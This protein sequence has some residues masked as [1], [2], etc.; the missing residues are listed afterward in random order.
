MNFAPAPAR[1]MDTSRASP[2]PYSY[3]IYGLQVH[4]DIELPELRPSLPGNPDIT[5]RLNRIERE[6]SPAPN[7]S[8]AEFDGRQTF[9]AWDAV[10]KFLITDGRV[11]EIEPAADVDLRL[12]AFPLLGPVLAMALHDRGIFVL[13]ASAIS[14]AGSGIAF[15]GDKGA[16]KST[17]A[18][19][20]I[21]AGHKLLSDDVV[22]LFGHGDGR[23]SIGSAFPQVKLA[24]DAAESIG[25][26]GST[27]MEAAHPSIT[28]RL[29]R[30]SINFEDSAA[31]LRRIFVLS[32]GD[33]AAI[34]RLSGA[35]A[36]TALAK[37]S[38]AA[39]FGGSALHGEGAAR[40][41]ASIGALLGSVG[42]NVLEVP[43]G[44]GRLDEVAQLIEADLDQPDRRRP[45]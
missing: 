28:K 2:A 31:P 13:H 23:W 10:G 14:F 19:A 45:A 44:L 21:A 9:L 41:L 36:F 40:H 32:R 37:F 22:A 15:L 42:V 25:V 34:T 30:L 3:R 17:T 11:I 24:D 27:V 38:Y 5:I 6:A 7:G 16:G 33:R 12:I 29:H 43:T 26:D 35:D 18:A 1:T 8:F 4:S 20:M 39:R